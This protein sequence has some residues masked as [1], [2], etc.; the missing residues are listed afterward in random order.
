MA[1]ITFHAVETPYRLKNKLRIK[2]WLSSVIA[3]E[4]KRCGDI[5]IIH[6][7]DD[8]LL[9]INKEHLDH[10]YFTDIITFDYSEGEVVS[11]DLF[12]SIERV[13]ENA[14]SMGEKEE[15]EGLRI[16]V[17]GVLHLLG[18]QDKT[19]EKKIIMTGLEDQYLSLYLTS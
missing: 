3:M 15:L 19:P 5:A 18:Y 10:D 6:C 8:Y 14:Q 11:G 12:I 1:A 7:S 2:R 13:I 4:G 9:K 17:H 16:M